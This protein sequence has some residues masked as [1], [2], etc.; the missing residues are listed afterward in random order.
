M[1]MCYEMYSILIWGNA[2]LAWQLWKEQGGGPGV[3]RGPMVAHPLGCTLC[4]APRQQSCTQAE[5]GSTC[6]L[7][8]P[9][10]WGCTQVRKTELCILF[11]IPVH[12]LYCY[13]AEYIRMCAYL[14]IFI[15][16]FPLNCHYFYCKLFS[17]RNKWENVIWTFLL[18]IVATCLT[19]KS[20]GEGKANKWCQ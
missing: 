20:L 3:S 8:A 5:A 16:F 12:L 13:F 14:F 9:R 4:S 2:S 17:G 18:F 1:Y 7:W 6:P 19:F 10:V 11:L 15:Y